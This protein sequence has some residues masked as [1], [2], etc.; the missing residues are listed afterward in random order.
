M[1][2]PLL[3]AVDI[4]NSSTKVG[5]FD[6]ASLVQPLPQPTATGEFPTGQTPPEAVAAQ[7]PAGPCR[8]RIASVHRE[9]QRVL[10][11]WVDTHRQSD[12]LHV[13]VYR[14]L[15]LEL[16][17]DFP[18]RVGVDRL[19]AA[20]AGN[21]IRD[22]QRPCIVIDAG[23]AITVDLVSAK[24][25]FEGGVILAGFKMQAEALFGGADLLPLTVLAPN[26]QPPKPLGKNTDAAIKSGLFWGAVGAVRE[27]V[28]QLSAPL[29][30]PPQVF[31]T[32][33]DLR[34]LAEHLDGAHYV[35]NLVLAGIAIAAR[36]S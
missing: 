7:L 36:A 18:E 33:G 1:S 11:K 24:G 13:L 9:G 26:E 12:E 28:V 16:R 35:P 3:I 2:S 8:W 14:D 23:S 10:S 15:P 17:V 4:G 5:W 21:A 27:I 22:P 30:P 19:A 20:V 29:N 32:G 31:V 25:A 34:R 6:A